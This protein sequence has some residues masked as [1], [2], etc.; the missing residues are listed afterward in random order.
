[1][2]EREALLRG[3]AHRALACLTHIFFMRSRARPRPCVT[4]ACSLRQ[5]TLFLKHVMI[6]DEILLSPGIPGRL[7][8]ALSAAVL[9][10]LVQLGSFHQMSVLMWEDFDI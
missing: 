7:R 6:V 5:R 1:M 4:R 3:V 10:T 9:Q 8:G 2:R